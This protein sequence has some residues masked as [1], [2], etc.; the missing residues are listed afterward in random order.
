[1]QSLWESMIPPI[2]EIIAES[3]PARLFYSGP[4]LC[5]PVVKR[6]CKVVWGRHMLALNTYS[7]PDL[8][9]VRNKSTWV[10]PPPT[11]SA[12]RGVQLSYR[13]WATATVGGAPPFS[14]PNLGHSRESPCT[15]LE[16]DVSICWQRISRNRQAPKA[17]YRKEVG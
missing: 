2:C 9:H 4:Y 7:M 15:S 14:P 16:T 1:M 3:S 17:Q 13:S 5:T 12:S 10:Q 6:F 11:S 8:R